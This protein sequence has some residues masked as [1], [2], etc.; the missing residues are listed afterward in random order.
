MN[1]IS[2]V[3]KI[4]A[5]GGNIMDFLRNASKSS[6]NTTEAILISYDFQAGTYVEFVRNNQEFVDKYTGAIANV[7]NQLPCN[8]LIEAGVGEATTL[9]NVVEHLKDRPKEVYGFDLSWSRIKYG[10]KYL[11]EK[12]I[13]GNLFTGNLFSAPIADNSVDIVYTS[14]SIEPNG[15]KEREALMELYRITNKYLVLLEPAY[16]YADDAGKERMEKLRYVKGLY[17]IAKALGYKIIEYRKFD[18]FSNPLNPTGLI[19]IEKKGESRRKEV[20]ACP[21][22]KSSLVRESNVYFSRESSLAYP[23]VADVP[24]L[25]PENAV[26]AT[27]FNNFK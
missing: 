18:Y 24:C 4:Y 1:Q 10:Q 12:N 14:H 6:N 17:G 19:V 8:S 15:G 11:K 5:R 3:K 2:E 7:I 26:L 16:E 20:L 13:T 21:I 27:H 9:G 22:S 23:I 25:L